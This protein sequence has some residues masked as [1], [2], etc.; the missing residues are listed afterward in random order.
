MKGPRHLP[1]WLVPAAT[2]SLA[3]ARGGA[4]AAAATAAYAE[5]SGLHW[6]DGVI[7]AAYAL[8]MIALG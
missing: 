3:Q 1:L 6:I 4:Q 2:L 7:I 8:G 5:S